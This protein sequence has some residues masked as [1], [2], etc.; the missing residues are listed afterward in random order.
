[1]NDILELWSLPWHA[2]Q[3][4]LAEAFGGENVRASRAGAEAGSW[5]GRAH[6]VTPLPRPDH[7]PRH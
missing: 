3:K 7:R 5:L 2:L 4:S 1:M 6:R